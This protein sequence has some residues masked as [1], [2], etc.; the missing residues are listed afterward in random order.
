MKKRKS[1]RFFL[2][3][4]GGS[5]A[6]LFGTRVDFVDTLTTPEQKTPEAKGP[7]YL[8]FEPL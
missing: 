1:N 8:T 3:L 5:L 6:H 7:C 4:R 2:H